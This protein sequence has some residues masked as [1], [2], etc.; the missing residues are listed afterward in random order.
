MP[1]HNNADWVQQSI[2][3]FS[4]FYPG[5]LK[6]AVV[7]NG[8]HEVTRAKLNNFHVQV[9]HLFDLIECDTNLGYGMGANRGLNHLWQ[10]E[11]FD[12]FGVTNDDVVPHH[13]CLP[14]LVSAFSELEAGEFKPGIL[15]PVSNRVAGRQLVEFAPAKDFEQLMDFASLH[16]RQHHSEATQVFQVRGLLALIHPDALS[17]IGGFDPIFGLG[18]FE[19]DDWN[20]RAKL[21]GYSLWVAD[22]AFLYHEGST[23]FKKLN[24]DYEAN[25]NRNGAIF[26]EKWQSENGHEAF[27][28]EAL[29]EGTDLYVPLLAKAPNSNFKFQTNGETIDLVYQATE[30]DFAAWVITNLRNQPRT[31]RLHVLN[32]LKKAASKAA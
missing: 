1:T 3:S 5:E 2:L 20:I 28:L 18:N 16:H 26:L 24:L 30:V 29:P 13:D 4:K 23:T 31:S 19:D 22:G 15:G 14:Q 27:A 12:Y 8:C 7:S 11:W 25:I 10:E 21:A 6:F 17:E 9:P 32:A